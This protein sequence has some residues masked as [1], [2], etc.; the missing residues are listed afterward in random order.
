MSTSKLPRY[1][2][3]SPLVVA[4]VAKTSG[5]LH[6]RSPLVRILA[7]SA[8][9]RALAQ[10]LVLLVC[11]GCAHR[12][13]WK[14]TSVRVVKAPELTETRWLPG[15]GKMVVKRE[16]GAPRFTVLLQQQAMVAEKQKREF[17]GN[18]IVRDFTAKDMLR[19]PIVGVPAALI[20]AITPIISVATS[21]VDVVVAWPLG[22]HA[23]PADM[24]SWAKLL[25]TVRT[26]AIFSPKAW[27]ESTKVV[28]NGVTVAKKLI[29]G[30]LSIGAPIFG[31][32]IKGCDHDGDGF[33]TMDYLRDSWAY[34]NPFEA[35]PTGR[36]GHQRED[37]PEVSAK[38][39]PR[40]KL[41][42]TEV[43]TA[44]QETKLLPLAG[45]PV[46]VKID[47]AHEAELTTDKNG[48]AVFKPSGDL[49][50][51]GLQVSFSAPEMAT[52][53]SASEK[54]V[55]VQRSLKPL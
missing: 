40:G 48:R 51:E 14:D 20:G 53:G 5:D 32:A 21:V 31:P 49:S 35:C 37:A 4:E 13:G 1:A 10:S 29:P 23:L 34:L 27:K 3:R 2:S 25:L 28:K 46:T 24:V 6:R 12:G 43:T 11:V 30:I 54:R 41:I 33:D 38:A 9:S 42:G 36:R 18:Q 52:S 50:G 47:G 15:T 55:A 17:Y 19:S 45:V 8:T 44:S 16:P 39:K 26:G 7:N 22:K